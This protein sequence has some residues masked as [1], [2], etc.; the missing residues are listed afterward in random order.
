M[1]SQKLRLRLDDLEVDSFDTTPRKGRAGEGTVY[2]FVT[3]LT[4]CNTCI[5]TDCSCA[6]VCTCQATCSY[7][8]GA[9]CGGTCEGKTCE[10]QCAQF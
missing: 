10:I 7:T 4:A 1:K 3:S 9:S 6:T 5:V 2:G 8:C